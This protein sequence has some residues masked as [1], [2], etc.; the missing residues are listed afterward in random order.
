MKP[1]QTTRRVESTLPGESV[2]M[3]IDASALTHIMSVLTDLYSDT[4]L[5]PIREY[6][7]NAYDAHIEAGVSLPI[8]VSTPS[9]LR[10]A[11]IIRDYGHG[12]DADDI[13]D[14]YSR[15]GASTKRETNDQVGMLGLGCKSA[16]TYTD[17]F[18]LT[19]IKGGVR[20]TVSVSRDATGAGSMKIVEQVETDES[21]GVEVVIPAKEY[22][23]FDR[24]AHEFFSYW[25]PGTVLINGEEPEPIEGLAITE[26]ITVQHG[27]SDDRIVM[28]NVPYPCDLGLSIPGRIVARVEIGDVEFVPSREALQETDRTEATLDRLRAEFED[29]VPDAIQRAVDAAESRPEALAAWLRAAIALGEHPTRAEASYEGVAMHTHLSQIGYPQPEGPAR[30]NGFRPERLAKFGSVPVRHYY[31]GQGY[32]GLMETT[33]ADLDIIGSVWCTGFTNKNFTAPMRRKLDALLRDR[34]IDPVGNIYLTPASQPPLAD[35]LDPVVIDWADV[36][37]TPD[38]EKASAG[39]RV[40]ADGTYEGWG[41]AGRNERIKP[42]TLSQSVLPVYYAKMHESYSG[43]RKALGGWT[44]EL[45]ANRVKKFLRL[46]PNA[47]PYQEALSDLA[48]RLWNGLSEAERW[49]HTCEPMLDLEDLDAAGIEDP[50]LAE[51]VELSQLQVEPTAAMQVFSEIETWA[52]AEFPDPWPEEIEHEITERYPLLSHVRYADPKDITFYINAVYR[53]ADPKEA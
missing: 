40:R 42:E 21:S 16:L 31:R 51:I 53:A 38:P 1:D 4:E 41:P 12:L 39:P 11:L 7:T 45:P 20:T 37:A 34:E 8:E 27:R 5:A 18:S 13:R 29:A 43:G 44:V 30:R 19:G 10:P 24:K 48:T 35:W 25:E 26:T 32:T 47:R 33:L 36:R 3:G 50:G 52:Y 17:Q 2:A 22:N 23:E 46:V 6:A 49:A 28:G 9:D 15:Y 14:I